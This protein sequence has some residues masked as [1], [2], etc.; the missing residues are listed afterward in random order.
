[1]AEYEAQARDVEELSGPESSP[2][3]DSTSPGSFAITLDPGARSSRRG[4]E[5]LVFAG[6]V[7]LHVA[8]YLRIHNDVTPQVTRFVESKVEIELAHPPPPEEPKLKEPEPPPDPP[9]QADRPI[10]HVA[11]QAPVAQ[12]TVEQPDNSNLPSSDEGLL[13]PTPP[14]T[15]TPGPAVAPPPPPP[16]PPPAAPEPIIP[17]RIGANYRSCRPLRYPKL[18]VREEWAGTTLLRVRVLANGR[19]G[20]VTIVKSA[21]HSVLDDE[22]I[23]R[24]KTCVFEPS[25]QGGKAIDGWHTAPVT[26][27][28][29]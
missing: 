21:G 10:P 29:Q 7:A 22:A 8:L 26:F 6:S 15:G 12:P 25:T 2:G 27:N 5:W 28:L 9:P 13:P 19:V 4:L 16:P 11:A 1:M 20:G 17:P 3:R 14:G 23:E 18:A 24:T